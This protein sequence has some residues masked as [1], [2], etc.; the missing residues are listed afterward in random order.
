MNSLCLCVIPEGI[1]FEMSALLILVWS[2]MKNNTEKGHVSESGN[3]RW[4]GTKHGYS[5]WPIWLL[6]PQKYW[7]PI[8]LSRRFGWIQIDCTVLS[9]SLYFSFSILIS[10]AICLS[11]LMSACVLLG[12]WEIYHDGVTDLGWQGEDDV[13]HATSYLTTQLWNILPLVNNFVML[14]SNL[15]FAITKKTDNFLINTKQIV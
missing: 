3:F 11:Q 13:C 14:F 9:T 12:N 1:F 2:Q 10:S 4:K 8:W 6:L 15:T 7:L 5:N